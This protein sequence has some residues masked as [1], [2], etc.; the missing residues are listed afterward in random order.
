MLNVNN[1][2][3]N[4]P[5]IKSLINLYDNYEI[6]STIKENKTDT[7]RSEEYLLL[8]K[9][10]NTR[11]MKTAMNWLVDNFY[12]VNDESEKIDALHH[13]WFKKR[14]GSTSG[15]EQIFMAEINPGEILRGAQNWIYFNHLETLKEINYMGYTDK[16]IIKNVS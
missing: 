8:D 16:L 13:I 7:M 9:F 6:N 10:M 5:T 2:I 15:F 4:F 3:L 11:V 12:I 1:E 14:R